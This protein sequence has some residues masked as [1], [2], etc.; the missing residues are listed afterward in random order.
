[1][2]LCFACCISC[3]VRRLVVTCHIHLHVARDVCAE[4]DS[5]SHRYKHTLLIDL[6][7]IKMSMVSSTTKRH[8]LQVP[9]APS[10]QSACLMKSTVLTSFP[11]PACLTQHI[12]GIGSKY[13]PE[14]IWK[15]YLING[16]MVFKAIFALVKPFLAVTFPHYQNN[17]F[18]SY[19][20]HLLKLSSRLFHRLRP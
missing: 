19:I 13:F 17:F 15:I 12:F 7:H 1:M 9:R 5:C 11:L 6:S 14:T 4:V 2:R 16:P 10:F 8:C 3:L 18:T 20:G